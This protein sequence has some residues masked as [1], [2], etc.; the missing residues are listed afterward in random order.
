MSQSNYRFNAL[1]TL[2]VVVHS[3][4]MPVGFCFPG[5]GIKTKG[6][7]LSVIAHLKTSIIEVKAETN[8]LARALV[9][10]IA[11]LTNDPNYRQDRKIY[12]VV[13]NLI[14]TTG[15]NLDNVRGIPNSNVFKTISDNIR[16]SCMRG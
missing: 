10:A 14:E 11:K 6:R 2:T 1:E 5:N 13:S 7:K 3:V 15:I 9:I 4:T 12:P 8:C 16:T